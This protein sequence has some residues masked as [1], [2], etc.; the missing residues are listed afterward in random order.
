MTFKHRQ[1]KLSELNK[2]FID[3]YPKTINKNGCWIPP[4][5]ANSSGHTTIMIEGVVFSLHRISMCIDR[6]INYSDKSFETRHGLGCSPSCFNYNHLQPGSVRDNARDAVA[7]GTHHEVAK[8]V[9]P[10]CQG[11]YSKRIIKSGRDKGKIAR[12][13]RICSNDWNRAQKKIKT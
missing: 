4:S 7:H 13:C 9:C 3:N 12:Y 5:V 2:S 8:K 6:N 11:E 1:F 10:K